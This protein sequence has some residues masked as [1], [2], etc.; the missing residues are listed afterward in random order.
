MA[1]WRLLAVAAAAGTIASGCAPKAQFLKSP[2]APP[3]SVAVLPFDN[4]SNSLEAPVLMQKLAADALATGGY[5]VVPA[6]EVEAKLRELG[7]SQ[8]GQVRSRKT[9]EMAAAL[10]ASA[11]L[12]GEVRKF[13]YMT[14]GVYMKREVNVGLELIAADGS[15]LWK[16]AAGAVRQDIEVDAAKHGRSFVESLGSQLAMKWIERILSHP[17]YPEMQRSIHDVFLTLPSA[18]NPR[19]SVGSYI[20]SGY[21]DALPL[22]NMMR[23]PLGR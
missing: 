4:A 22:G 10:G 14:I 21:S 16:H 17:L 8:G 7:I 13:S 9:E 2:Y 12:Y 15:R 19:K 11:L 3:R 1:P 18:R 20:S 5:N 6:A 23:L